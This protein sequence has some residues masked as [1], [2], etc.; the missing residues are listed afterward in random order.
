MVNV[1]TSSEGFDEFVA[2]IEPALRRALVLSFGPQAGREAC[3]DALAW[4]W[5]NWTRVSAMSNPAGYLYRVG[6]TCARRQI[7]G[8]GRQVGSRAGD[9]EMLVDPVP[10]LMPALAGL[11]DQQ[12]V[13]VVL[14]H[15]YGYRQTE[16]AAMLGVTVSTLR[17]HLR[18]GVVRLREV[19]EVT[20]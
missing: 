14:V 1:W 12:R 13:A 19:L 18:R 3:I 16:V 10:E 2:R 17:E 11:S 5:E 9:D 4:A 7:V 20:E 15:G 8:I 6:Q